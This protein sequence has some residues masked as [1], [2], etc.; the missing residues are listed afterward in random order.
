[1]GFLKAL[2]EAK[3]GNTN[4]N[5]D[6]Q[7]QLNH[8]ADISTRKPSDQIQNLVLLSIA[9]SFRVDEKKYPD[10]LRLRFGIGFPNEVFKSLENSGYLRRS[11]AIETLPHMKATE[12]KSIA[13]QFG[14]KSSGTKDDICV[15]IAEIVTEK[16]LAQF[17][18]DRYWITTETGKAQLEANPYISFYTSKHTYSWDAVGLDINTYA[19]LFSGK[20]TGRVRDIIWQYFNRSSMDLYNNGIT[21]G[22]FNDYTEMLHTMALFLEEENRHQD[23]LALYMRYIYYR[24]NFEASLSAFRYYSVDKNVDNAADIVFRYAEILPYHANEIIDISNCCGFDSKQLQSFIQEAFSKEQDQGIFS[25]S[26]LTEFVM[27]GLN[28]DQNGQKRICRSA[29]L[30]AAKKLPR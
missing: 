8:N 13:A 30:L 7:P 23:A 11:T 4:V 25:P 1:M 20:A 6:T 14:L 5:N 16:A 21:K 10:Y 2:F 29:M 18:P 17:V 28:G 15:R 19:K 3:K 22:D 26:E 12:L 27:F 24:A 9:E